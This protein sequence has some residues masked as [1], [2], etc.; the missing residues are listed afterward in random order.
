MSDKIRV[1]CGECGGKLAVPATAAGKKVRCPKCQAT[2][3]VPTAGG[4]K[5]KRPAPAV[6]EED[7]DDPYESTV[8]GA[9]AGPP[10][11]T[12][13]KS[14]T[15]RR[16]A[17]KS[18]SGERHWSRKAIVGF[19]IMGASVA[20]NAV[21]LAI[22]GPPNM[23]TAQGQGQAAGQGVVTICGLIF[24]LV[25]VVRSFLATRA[26]KQSV[27]TATILV[28]SGSPINNLAGNDSPIPHWCEGFWTAKTLVGSWR[29]YGPRGRPIPCRV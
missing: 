10:P 5:K 22:M 17:G 12:K 3:Q 13:K 23:K 28:K 6:V 15:S 20:S 4:Q 27:S 18:K 8:P 2:I 11:R 26:E 21:Q 14:A 16:K 1:S 9:D 29:G 24:G 7:Y 19:G 25:I